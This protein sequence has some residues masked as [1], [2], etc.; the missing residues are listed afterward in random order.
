MFSVFVFLMIRRPP[1]STRTD[2]LFPYTALF[3][4]LGRAF[5]RGLGADPARPPEEAPDGLRPGGGH[6]ADVAAGPHRRG[7]RGRALPGAEPVPD[8]KS[9]RL[10][11]SH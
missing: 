5:A 4:S 3:R 6:E 1:R 7:R 10:N 8:R 2:T 11:S 9:T